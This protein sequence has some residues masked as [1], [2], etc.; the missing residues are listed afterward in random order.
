[1][2]KK[3]ATLKKDGFSFVMPFLFAFSA[4]ILLIF[5][6]FSLI[7]YLL[8]KI[9]LPIALLS[10][11]STSAVCL[12]IFAAGILLAYL[13]KRKGMLSG[14]S[15]GIFLFLIVLVSALV[16]GKNSFSALAF[17]KLIAFC[18]AGGIGGYLGILLSEKQ[19]R[20]RHR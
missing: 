12:S 19:R 15:L 8:C 7:C 1:M 4:A 13:L 11:L 10:P 18:A 17:I 5:A 9:D 2:T 3:A 20:K 6:Q 14:F 16:Q